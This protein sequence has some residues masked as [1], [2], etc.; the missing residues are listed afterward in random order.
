MGIESE[1]VMSRTTTRITTRVDLGRREQNYPAGSRGTCGAVT[2]VQSAA[3]L[4][5]AFEPSTFGT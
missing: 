5:L 2:P 1:A 4:L 3:A